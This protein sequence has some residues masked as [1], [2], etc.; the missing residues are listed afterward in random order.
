MKLNELNH[1]PKELRRYDIKKSEI[2][3]ILKNYGFTRIGNNSASA[4]VYEHPNFD[5][6]LKIFTDDDPYVQFYKYC[7]KNQSNP[8]LPKFRGN[9]MRFRLSPVFVVRIEKLYPIS[10]NEYV[11]SFDYICFIREELDYFYYPLEKKIEQ[12]SNRFTELE[13]KKKIE[14]FSKTLL[15]KTLLELKD[16]NSRFDLHPGNIMKR[17]NGTWVLIDPFMPF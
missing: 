12:K 1:P 3:N 9:L 11:D 8:H 16:I 17:D 2:T 14:K 5:Y 13:I 4:V 10:H 7:K 15:G 6:I